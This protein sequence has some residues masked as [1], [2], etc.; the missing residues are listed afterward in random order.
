MTTTAGLDAGGAHLKVALVDNGQVIDARQIVCPLWQGFDQLDA[1]LTEA[2]PLTARA[3]RFAVTMTG[4]L[5]D[6]FA[7]RREGVVRLVL[8]LATVF[9]PRTRFWMG[10]RGFGA[11]KDAME[12][13]ASVASTNFLATAALVASRAENALLVDMGSTTT[14]IIPIVAG[15]PAP[16]GLSDA[17]RLATGELVYTGL[18][19]TALMAVATKAPFQGRRQGLAREYFA[20]MADV[21]RILGELPE[22]V[23]R[24]ETADKKGKSV[25]ESLARLARMFGRDASDGTAE[26]WRHAARFFAEE[27]SRS[28]LDGCRQVLSA[29]PLP[30]EASIIQ[31]GIGAEVLQELARRLG[32]ASKDFGEL[33][34][35]PGETRLWATRCAPA[36]AVALR[37]DAPYRSTAPAGCAARATASGSP[38]TARP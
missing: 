27:Q 23:D 32:F 3:S 11:A 28:I 29:T 37:R 22:G 31:A 34:S 5:S 7:D 4:E 26:E 8:R 1:A 25:E 14:D 21:R 38:R 17:E 9:G 35:G 20:T 10:Q 19:R 6:L 12:D 24:H 16:R 2:L 30:I 18:T 13:F 36:V 15:R 33:V